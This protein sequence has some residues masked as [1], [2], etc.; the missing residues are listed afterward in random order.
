[1][2]ALWRHVKQNKSQGE[3]DSA[4]PPPHHRGG[5]GRSH[6]GPVYGT[7]PMGV[8]GGGGWQG[9]VHIYIYIYIYILYIYIYTSL[10]IF[11]NGITRTRWVWQCRF[12]PPINQHQ[13]INI[14][15]KFNGSTSLRRMS[16]ISHETLAQ[17][18]SKNFIH[19]HVRPLPVQVSTV[20]TVST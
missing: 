3:G 7:H 14:N 6:M 5:G 4:T 16:Q 12:G 15:L 1:M 17:K 18:D 13:H 10:F 20:S 11:D 2:N 19:L 9:L 8:G